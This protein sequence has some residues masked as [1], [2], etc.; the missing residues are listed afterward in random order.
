MDST[1]SI[2]IV[3]SGGGVRA[4]AFHAGVFQYLAEKNC[5]DSIQHVS[6]VSGGSLFVGLIFKLNGYKW[7]TSDEYLKNIMPA[8]Q[9]IL[10]TRS[11]HLKSIFLLLLNPL[12]W[13]YAASRAEVTAKAFHSLWDI[14]ESLDALPAKPE[15]SINAT[16]AE[17]GRRFRF[18]GTEVG[19]YE[20]GYA[21]AKKFQIASA[22]AVSSA[23]P[24]LIG[25]LTFDVTQYTW[26]KRMGWDISQKPEQI[27]P[28]FTKLH[29]YDGGIYDNLGLEPFFDGGKQEMKKSPAID[30]LIVSDAGAAYVR[31]RT[32][33]SICPGRMLK[34]V[35]IL[36]DQTRSL[37][38]RAL[39]NFAIKNP[40]RSHYIQIGTIPVQKI[41]EYGSKRSDFAEI[42][43]SRNWLE[44]HQVEFAKTYRTSLRQMRVKDFEVIAAH[45]YQ[46]ATWNDILFP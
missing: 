12:N 20:F 41:K 14:K 15:W 30:R 24:G 11:I 25:P 23:V 5:L 22:L 45:G 29:L 32:P 46:T 26:F 16:S 44:P 2:G 6:S 36:M 28:Q 8:I 4:A 38:V 19:D 18:K 10:T 43:A 17:T 13:R 31:S 35:N 34:I 27:S 9:N 37:R 1:K 21:E 40:G 7:P 39:V 3:L 42:L 33:I